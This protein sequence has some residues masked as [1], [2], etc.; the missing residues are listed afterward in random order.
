MNGKPT[1]AAQPASPTP[2][3]VGGK[4]EA[5]ATDEPDASSG[6]LAGDDWSASVRLV[7]CVK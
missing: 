5:P 4:A 7:P 1:P 6:R 3:L 2:G